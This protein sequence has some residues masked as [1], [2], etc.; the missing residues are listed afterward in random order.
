[1]KKV[2][3]R[4]TML[5]SLLGLFLAGCLIVRETPEILPFGT[6]PIPLATTIESL[7]STDIATTT[8]TETLQ[9]FNP[10]TATPAQIVLPAVTMSPQEAKSALLDLLRTNGDCTGKCLAGIRPDDMTVQEAVDKLAQWGMVRIYENSVNGETYY[11]SVDIPF[12]ERV[13]VDFSVGT[14][15]KAP[16]FIH[17]VS[18]RIRGYSGQPL[19]ED[20]WLEN[21]E[22]WQGFRLDN[23]LKA[24]GAPSFVG[25]DYWT[26]VEIGK[27]LEGRTIEYGMIIYYEQINL[28][29]NL[30]GLA[31]YDGENLFICPTKDPRDLEIEIN[32][33][34]NQKHREE[35][36]EVTWE[37][38]TGTDL[39][40]FYKMFTDPANLESCITTMLDQIEALQPGF[41]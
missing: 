39:D 4:F 28:L 22:S 33:A 30:D 14:L 21:R 37:E 8:P 32:P 7:I 23:L 34:S 16:E 27:P 40:A 18:V 3:N 19:S 26:I 11:T 29:L 6:S 31:Y 5:L 20:I 41:R 13:R 38:L 2:F 25:S 36:Y 1:M 9:P 24:Y 12:D 35:V 10:S 15:T 17:D